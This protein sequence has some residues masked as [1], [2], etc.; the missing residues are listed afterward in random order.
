MLPRH[1]QPREQYRWTLAVEKT[2]RREQRRLQS[3]PEPS[4]L[5]LLDWVESPRAVFPDIVCVDSACDTVFKDMKS[6]VR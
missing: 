2:D 6:R 1:E 4:L 5:R 3:A